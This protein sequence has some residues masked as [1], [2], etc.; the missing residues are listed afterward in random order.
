VAL[1]RDAVTDQPVGIQRIHPLSPV[2][3]EKMSL[4]SWPK[5]N[6]AVIKLWP[7]GN[8]WT[9]AIGEGPENVMSAVQLDVAEP[10]AW[11]ATVAINLSR[12]PA[13]DQVKLLT[14]LADKDAS[15]TGERVTRQLR[16][17]WRARGK[18]VIARMPR[19]IRREV[20]EVDDIR[21]QGVAGGGDQPPFRPRA[22][23]VPSR[24]R[25]ERG[26]L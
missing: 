24:D 7:L 21:R 8:G 1:R 19:T 10:P 26:R 16:R 9:L 4:G 17:V 2:V 25:G 14:I 6:V 15:G 5:G 23:A 20:G 18:K 11:A 12:I 3:A 22:K 13:I